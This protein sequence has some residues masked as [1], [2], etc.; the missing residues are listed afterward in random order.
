M[1]HCIFLARDCRGIQRNI[2]RS[3]A[4]LACRSDH[5]VLQKERC[6]AL[7]FEQS[8]F[9]AQRGRAGSDVSVSF[10]V[11]LGFYMGIV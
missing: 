2:C 9:L 10:I 6:E 3:P 11:A 1:I 7:W 5:P 8:A 4:S